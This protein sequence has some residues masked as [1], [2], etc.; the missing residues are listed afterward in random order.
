[1]PFAS[2][3]RERK[4]LHVKALEDENLR[5][6]T[7]LLKKLGE[8]DELTAENQRLKELLQLAGAPYLESTQDM[9]IDPSNAA[10]MYTLGE[11][12][13]S[14]L[15]FGFS[16]STATN[17]AST[18]AAE[19]QTAPPNNDVDEKLESLQIG[20]NLDHDQIGVDFVLR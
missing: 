20:Q 17:T 6:K 15:D 13:I 10:G 2:T 3:H 14:G 12:G 5:V 9:N 11:T 18:P 7:E 4:I 1:M 16:P 19:P 8:V